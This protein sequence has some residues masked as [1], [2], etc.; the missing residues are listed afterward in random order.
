MKIGTEVEGRWA[1]IK[2]LFIETTEEHPEEARLRAIVNGHA[3]SHVY[4]GVHGSYLVEPPDALLRLLDLTTFSFLLVTVEWDFWRAPRLLTPAL[5]GR[6]QT[7]HLLTLSPDYPPP[8]IVSPDASIALL[9]HPAVELKLDGENRAAVFPCRP[10]IIDT[11]YC[12]DKE[13]K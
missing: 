2:T 13:V 6:P 1:G 12:R 7:R 8:E 10:T 3:I 9:A 5:L 11:T 4:V